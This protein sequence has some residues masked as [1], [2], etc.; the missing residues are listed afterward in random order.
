MVRLVSMGPLMCF[1]CCKISSLTRINTMW[2]TMRLYKAFGESTNSRY[3][4]SIASR[5]G[6][7]VSSVFSSKNK[8]LTLSWYKWFFNIINPPPDSWLITP[9]NVT[10]LEIQCWSLLLTH[11]TFSSGYSQVGSGEWK[12]L[13][14]SSIHIL[15]FC[16][17]VHFVHEPIGYWE[18]WLGKEAN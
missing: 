12:S 5:E 6:K 9:E 14:L 4:R 10:I 13:L 15:Q 1:I 7:S 2:N 16:H 17:H 18:G 11:W 8:I 3:G